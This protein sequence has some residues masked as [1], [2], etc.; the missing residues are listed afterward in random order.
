MAINCL[1]IHENKNPIISLLRAPYFGLKI[2]S[3]AFF[4][5]SNKSIKAARSRTGT[6]RAKL[7][8]SKFTT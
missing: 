7:P 5:L 6:R 1:F 2:T 3:W 4:W 8:R